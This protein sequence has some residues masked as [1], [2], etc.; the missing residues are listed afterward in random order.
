M[1]AFGNRSSNTS[2]VNHRS[3]GDGGKLFG[4]RGR[5]HSDEDGDGGPAPNL[6]AFGHF[7]SMTQRSRMHLYPD[8][9]G[10]SHF[11]TLGLKDGGGG[12]DEFDA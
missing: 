2:L 10:G 11:H 7:T 12:N 9:Q 6:V 3:N 8:L 4:S 1:L 5:L